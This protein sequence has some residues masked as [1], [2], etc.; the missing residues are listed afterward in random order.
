MTAIVLVRFFDCNN[1]MA[2]QI[3]CITEIAA[4]S[5]RQSA[6]RPDLGRKY[7]LLRVASPK[8]RNL[9]GESNRVILVQVMSYILHHFQLELA[10]PVVSAAVKVD[11]YIWPTMRSVSSRSLPASTSIL[12]HR[13]AR[14]RDDKP[15]YQSGVFR[16][17]LRADALLTGPIWLGR[18]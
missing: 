5:H 6:R 10:L 12:A 15:S 7:Q 4:S 17:D 9:G 11:S 18:E 2:L 16:V 8:H 13:Q 3:S 14:K 1:I